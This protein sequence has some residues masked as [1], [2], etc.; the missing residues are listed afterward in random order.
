MRSRTARLYEDLLLYREAGAEASSSWHRDATYW[1][2]RGH[3]LSSVWF[4]LESVTRETG[5]MRFVAASHLDPDEVA[6]APFPD[7]DADPRLRVIV[8]E[9]EP[10]DAILFHPRI[11]HTAY[12]SAPDRPRRT[13][14]IRFTGDD[15]RW[16]PRRAFF[17]P[18][19]S[20]CGLQK[21]D[22]LDHPGFPLVWDDTQSIPAP[23]PGVTA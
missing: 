1:P 19:M 20:D 18:W 2:L 3:Q 9:T 14:T 11:L 12:G 6:T 13:F 17:H 4:S 16:R 15:V 22:V 23:R 5:G 21:G 8:I 7:V 10:G